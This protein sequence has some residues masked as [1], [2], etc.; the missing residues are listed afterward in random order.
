MYIPTKHYKEACIHNVCTALFLGPLLLSFSINTNKDLFFLFLFF[1]EVNQQNSSTFFICQIPYFI[2]SNRKMTRHEI[3]FP[4]SLA[5]HSKQSKKLTSP[6]K[7]QATTP[8]TNRK[9][10]SSMHRMSQLWSM[11]EEFG[12][13]MWEQVT[14]P[15]GPTLT[16]ANMSTKSSA[17]SCTATALLLLARTP[18]PGGGVFLRL[19][20]GKLLCRSGVF[21]GLGARSPALQS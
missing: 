4:L 2:P 11:Q 1:Q 18:G 5:N 20:G 17:A 9:Y 7:C 10:S 21:Q 15:V 16:H 12:R 8:M 19:D 14:W 6:A 3:Y 13:L